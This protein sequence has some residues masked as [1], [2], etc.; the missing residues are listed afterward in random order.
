V[1]GA[2]QS[3]A[4]GREAAGRL[5]FHESRAPGSE[6]DAFSTAAAAPSAPSRTIAFRGGT[7]DDPGMPGDD[8]GFVREADAVMEQLL[9]RLSEEDPDELEAD[10]A[11]G[12]LTI[13]FA[14]GSRCVIN[15]QTAAH[16]I[17][18][19]VGASA[20]HF[21]RESD[22]RWLDTKGRG[23]LRGILARELAA[24]LGRRLEL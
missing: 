18:L 19:A 23:E 2:N 12:V 24:R 15:R 16:Q 7:S 1:A 21:A 13:Q 5:F 22:G 20:W 6:S 10:L 11:M 8:Q 4:G 9:D 3:P 17:W 14:D